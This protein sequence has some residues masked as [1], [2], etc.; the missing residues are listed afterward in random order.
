L[1]I[2]GDFAAKNR[3]QARAEVGERVARPAD[4]SENFALDGHDL[5][6]GDIVHGSD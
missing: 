3:A 5:E 1:G 4:E 6:T 2:A